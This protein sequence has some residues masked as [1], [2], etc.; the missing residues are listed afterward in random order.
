MPRRRRF[1]GRLLLGAPLI[2]LPLALT[3]GEPSDGG[4]RHEELR[5]FEARE[6]KQ[7]VAVDGEFFYAIDNR[8]IGKYRKDTGARVGGWDGGRGGRIQHLNAG[9][10][11]DGKLYAANSNFPSLPEESSIE[12]WD[13]ATMQHV[14]AH[15]FAAPPGSLTWVD[16]RDGKWFACFAHY[17]RTGDPARTRVV[18]LDAEWKPL[19]RWSFPRELIRRFG[20]YSSSGGAFGPGGHLFATGHDARELYVLDLPENGAELI[21]RATIPIRA[22]GQAFAWDLGAR[23]SGRT[24]REAGKAASPA[25]GVLYSIERKR[26]E[27]IVSRV[28]REVA[29]PH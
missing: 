11:L 4:W 15:R 28:T 2:G 8:A 20:G 10:V 26:R 14:G 22:A 12:I 25:S 6:A 21:W 27:V 29:L 13:T 24:A 17:E 7:G 19:A 18:E 9:V 1:A 3:A 16:R 23:S 5:R